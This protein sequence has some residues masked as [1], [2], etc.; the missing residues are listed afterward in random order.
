M[1]YI[2]IKK[3]LIPYRFRTT[4]DNEIYDFQINYNAEYDFF[5]IYLIRDEDIVLTDRIAYGRELF[6]DYVGV[7]KPTIPII[8]HDISGEEDEVTYNNLNE[9]VFLYL[10]DDNGII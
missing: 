8:P 10:G 1:E 7:D 6:K 3:E 4:I 2:E 5:T 9:N